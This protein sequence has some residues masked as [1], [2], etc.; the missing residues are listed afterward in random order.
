ML[1]SKIINQNVHGN[2]GHLQ[3]VFSSFHLSC[4]LKA[5]ECILKSLESNNLTA[6]EFFFFLNNLYLVTTLLMTILTFTCREK[7]RKEK[8]DVT[9][10]TTN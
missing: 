1:S 2:C 6:T 7:E 4:S 10:F 5:S 9:A 8:Y 3:T